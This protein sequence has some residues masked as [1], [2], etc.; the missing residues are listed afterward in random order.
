[1]DR[2]VTHS[3]GAPEAWIEA[4]SW[5]AGLA[6]TWLL[7]SVMA[8]IETGPAPAPEIED[9]RL[10]AAPIDLPPIPP[11]TEEPLAPV[12]ESL[13]VLGL[14]PGA[15]DSPVRIR[16]LPPEFEAL[17]PRAPLP[18]R[19]LEALGRVPASL[20]PRVEA[21]ED[22]RH[23]YQPSEVD[24]PPRAVVRTMPPVPQDLFGQANA[25]RVVLLL[26]IGRNGEVERVRVAS[27]SGQPIYDSLVIEYIRYAWQFTPAIRHG[28]PVR[29]LAEQRVGMVLRAS[30]NPFGLQ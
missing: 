23:I 25:L 29:C 7:F 11:R 3:R 1:M 30:A 26:T 8:R 14:E 19:Q 17:L 21:A 2:V 22:S 18:P 9:V 28:Q 13:P 6:I 27:P 15:S 12:A 5:A 20:K 24:Q 10:V 16:V 4:T